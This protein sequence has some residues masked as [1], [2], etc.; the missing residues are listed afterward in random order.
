M[1]TVSRYYVTTWLTQNIDHFQLLNNALEIAADSGNF[2]LVRT[3]LGAV[4]QLKQ[5]HLEDN[6]HEMFDMLED[7]SDFQL[8][9]KFECKS[10]LVPFLGS[11]TPSDTFKIYK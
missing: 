7:I 2:E 5:R 8:D 4:N 10:S 9:M 11:V 6:R 1:K 3:L